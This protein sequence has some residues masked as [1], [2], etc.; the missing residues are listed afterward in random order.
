MGCWVEQALSI[1]V[2]NSTGSYD[3]YRSPAVV[4]GLTLGICFMGSLR[5][6]TP[7][8]NGIIGMT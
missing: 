1:L 5:S 6:V 4:N 7:W 3:G 2:E 8:Y